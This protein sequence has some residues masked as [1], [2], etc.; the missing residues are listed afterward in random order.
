[1]TVTQKPLAASESAFVYHGIK[2][3]HSYVSQ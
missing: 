3:G 1:M 2:H